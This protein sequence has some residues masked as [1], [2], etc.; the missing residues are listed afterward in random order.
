MPPA[1]RGGNVDA[2]RSQRHA[3]QVG[4]VR[5]FHAP[6]VVAA[7]GRHKRLSSEIVVAGARG[8]GE[9]GIRREPRTKISRCGRS[10]REDLRRRGTNPYRNC[11]ISPSQQLSK[12]RMRKSSAATRGVMWLTALGQHESGH[13][14]A[15][16]LRRLAPHNGVLCVVQFRTGV[17]ALHVP[18]DCLSHRNNGTRGRKAPNRKARP[19]AR[20]TA[21]AQRRRPQ[22]STWPARK[23]HNLWQEMLAENENSC[24]ISGRRKK[25]KQTW[26][27]MVPSLGFNA[28]QTP[29]RASPRSYSSPPPPP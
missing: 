20:R 2:G 15:A 23:H 14:L 10:P 11:A 8:R 27:M 6:H 18:L 19:S 24:V 28:I 9:G 29:P 21:R 26:R 12:T 17:C 22:P 5:A 25:Q 13:D 7:V 16:A 4:S 3:V 1:R